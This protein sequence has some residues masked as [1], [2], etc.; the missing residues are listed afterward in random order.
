MSSLSPRLLISACLLVFDTHAAWSQETAGAIPVPQEKQKKLVL[1]PVLVQSPEYLWG[2]GAAGT[3]FFKLKRDSTTRTSSFNMVGF[4]TLR[5]QLVI[6]SDGNVFF[7]NEKYILQTRLSYSKFPDRFWGL[8]NETSSS[9]Q[10][11]YEIR[12][13]NIYPRLLRNIFSDFYLGVGYEYQDVFRFEYNRDGTSLFDIENITG[14]NGGKISGAVLLFTWD[15]RNHA[16]SPSRGFYM[17][18]SIGLRFA[19]RPKEKLNLRIDAGFGKDSKGTYI[20]IGEAF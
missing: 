19:L 12:Q 2:F 16:F 18:Y 14:R 4:Y 10:E 9:N 11:T 6:A 5:H 8:G 17:Q 15:S 1:F 7:Q 20:N 3:Y 13:F